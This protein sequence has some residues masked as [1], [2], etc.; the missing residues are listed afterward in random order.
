MASITKLF[1]EFWNPKKIYMWIFVLVILL[2]IGAY[3]VYNKSYAKTMKFKKLSDIP[4]A[5]SSDSVQIMFF[6]VDWCPHCR[7]AKTPWEDFVKGYHNKK[8]NGKIVVCKTFNMTEIEDENDPKYKDYMEAKSIG[9]KYKIDG[10]PSIKMRQ[11]DNVVDFD[12][13]ITTYAL[14]QFVENML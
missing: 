5:S 9:D 14:E 7:N 10:F 1:L 13:K 8:V 4:N 12:A 3:Y 11:G 2:S 6:T